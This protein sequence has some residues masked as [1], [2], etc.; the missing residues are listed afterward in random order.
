[1]AEK[2]KLISAA[3]LNERIE[4]PGWRVIDCR[5]D[6]V[7]PDSGRRQYLESHVPGAVFADLG[8]D[9]AAPVSPQ[10][11]RHPLP[12]AVKF[13]ATLSRLGI[14][15]S[16]GVVVY[17]S[18]SGA[19]A[20]RAWWL[21][22][23]AGN[24]NVRLLDGGFDEWRRRGHS[25]QSGSK[26]VAPGQFTA[27]PRHDLVITTEELIEAGDSIAELLLIDARDAIRFRGEVEPID[28]V[29][30]HIPGALNVPLTL[31]LNADGTWRAPGELE[32]LW[33]DVLGENRAVSWA[34]MCG[35]GVTA[36]HLALSGMEAGYSEPRV[37][38]GSWSEW[39]RDP[40][41]PVALGP[42]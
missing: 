39:I 18:A 22:R 38:V 31:S 3:E 41:R 8:R 36:C 33:L 14:S 28:P 6:L 1:M 15:N 10:S 9:L 42:T 40:G 26:D 37:Y 16:T 7:D 11:G 35:S 27:A 13:E 21:L 24:D 25:V 19:L 5:F 4:D 17:D 30:G 12:H 2:S 34:V 20:A 23:W 32:A 29:A